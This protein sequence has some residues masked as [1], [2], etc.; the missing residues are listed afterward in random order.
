MNNQVII[1]QASPS[2]IGA[3]ALI[4]V[5]GINVRQIVTSAA[6]LKSKKLLTEVYTHSI[7]YGE[8]LS[9]EGKLIDQVLFFVM[10]SPRSFTG[11]DSIEI[12]C[13]NNPFIIQHIINR[14]IA[15]G[16]RLALPGEFSERAVKNKKIDIFQAEA[17]NELLHAQNEL[18]T[19][20]ALCQLEGSLSAAIKEIDELLCTVTAWCQ[21]SFEFLEEERDFHDTIIFQITGIEKK[22]KII[23]AQN[24]FY[25]IFKEGIKIAIIGSVNVGK[26]SL[27]NAL[28][29]VKRAIVTQ[30]PGTTRDT[31]EGFL[32]KNNMYWTFIDTAGIRLTDDII[33]EE[34]IKKS[35]IAAD[36]AEIVLLV[37]TKDMFIDKNIFHLYRELYKKYKDKIIIV[38]NKID[39]ISN[40]SVMD[41]DWNEEIQESLQVKISTQTMQG[42]S[43]LIDSLEK[44]IE[45][46]F[47]IQGLSYI[48]NMRHVEN[49]K[50]VLVKLD[51]VRNLL[52]K[53]TQYYEIIMTYLIEAQEIISL[54]SGKTIEERSFDKVFRSFC[55]GK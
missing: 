43:L 6:V 38:E 3:I 32:Y 37:Y 36:H 45:Q 30:I 27:L 24:N 16:A 15:C 25:T 34:G 14:I 19:Q 10:D 20:T 42:M 8:I 46:K 4:R 17:I 13:H 39:I 51:E 11:E 31:V 50:A 53:T 29:G 47:N 48:V 44:M 28:L 22:I 5:S 2:G 40:N 23:L 33:E 1:A 35:Y 54:L 9:E 41:I 49:L 12:T 7:H 55:V 26:S 18:M 52:Q 21:A